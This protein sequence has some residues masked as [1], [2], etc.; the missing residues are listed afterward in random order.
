M[1]ALV[2][3]VEAG[4]RK[5]R[6]GEVEGPGV[7]AVLNLEIESPGVGPGRGKVGIIRIKKRIVQ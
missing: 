3:G 7:K 1:L 4:A 2:L 5:R 6:A